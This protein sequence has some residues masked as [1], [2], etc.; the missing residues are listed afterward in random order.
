MASNS[1]IRLRQVDHRDSSALEDNPEVDSE[2]GVQYAP[3][4]K[5][6]QT[7]VL[8]SSFMAVFLTIGIN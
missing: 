3:I 7:I 5:R 4:T 6:R 8:I 1:E 2:Q